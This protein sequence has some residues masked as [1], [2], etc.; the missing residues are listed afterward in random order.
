MARGALVTHHRTPD[1]FS[2][3]EAE[4]L[5]ALASLAGV[6]L[7]NVRLQNETKA[8]A[9]RAEVLADMA[10]IISSSLDTEALLGALIREVQRVV[11][12]DRGSF[13]F[14]DPISHT[15][16][17]REVFLRGRPADVPAANRARRADRL[18]AGHA[19]RPDRRP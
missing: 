1:S 3:T 5:A 4:M 15:I 7:E 18:L 16:T 9:H 13:A 10:R 12:C 14:Y 17:F 11:P 2:E 19:H 8:Q 6:A